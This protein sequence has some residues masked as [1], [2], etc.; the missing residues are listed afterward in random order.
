MAFIEKYKQFYTK[1]AFKIYCTKP[2]TYDLIQMHNTICQEVTVQTIS[3]LEE[4]SS[5]EYEDRQ[6]LIKVNTGKFKN[7]NPNPKCE[8]GF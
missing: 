5:L 8:N 7:R 6:Q 4:M 3:T 1:F 2:L